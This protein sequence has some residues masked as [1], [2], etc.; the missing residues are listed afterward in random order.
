MKNDWIAANNVSDNFSDH[1]EIPVF[2]YYDFENYFFINIYPYM[3]ISL[4]GG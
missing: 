2:E 3:I 4:Q 1:V